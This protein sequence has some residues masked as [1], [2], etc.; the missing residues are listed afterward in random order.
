MVVARPV[1]RRAVGDAV[2]ISDKTNV[3]LI[4]ARPG[5]A[6]EAPT[7]TIGGS[8]SDRWKTVQITGG[9]AGADVD[10]A[11]GVASISA[12][13]SATV[14]RRVVRRTRALTGGSCHCVT[15]RIA[16]Y[17][18]IRAVVRTGWVVEVAK[19]ANVARWACIL[20]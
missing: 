10:F 4:A 6:L 3:T 16:A 9:H 15:V 14:W 19:G 11:N 7:N 1:V 12:R 5:I 13:A 17:K 2:R 20:L 8:Q 18:G